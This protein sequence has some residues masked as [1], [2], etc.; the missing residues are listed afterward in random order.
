MED[1]TY[2]I[3]YKGRILDG[4]DFDGVRSQLVEKFSLSREK[5]EQ[6]LNGKRVIIKKN[7]DMAAAK[8]IGLALKKAGLDVVMTQFSIPASGM[9]SPGESE[10]EGAPMPQPEAPV[11]NVSEPQEHKTRKTNCFGIDNIRPMKG[12]SSRL[13]ERTQKTFAENEIKNSKLH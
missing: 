8:K 2:N 3:V 6:L 7:L 13:A 1:L 11:S 12:F 10:A 5:A 9:P 4:H